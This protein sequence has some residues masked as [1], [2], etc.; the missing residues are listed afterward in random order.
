MGLVFLGEVL[1]AAEPGTANKMGAT[2][3]GGHHH[4]NPQ[5]RAIL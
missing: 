1:R 5:F 2:A 4:E 3:A